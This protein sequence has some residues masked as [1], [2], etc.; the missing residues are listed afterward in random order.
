MGRNQK[1]AKR[2]ALITGVTGTLG[3]SFCQNHHKDYAIIGVARSGPKPAG[4]DII[5]HGDVARDYEDIIEEALDVHGKVDYLINNAATY[6]LKSIE[7]LTP[8]EML[9]VLNVNVVGPY[10]LTRELYLKFW[11]RRPE[12]NLIKHRQVLNVSSTSAFKQYDK[13]IAYGVSKCA[14]NNLSLHLKKELKG[15]NITSGTITPTSFPSIVTTEFVAG[16]IVDLD[17]EG[18][19]YEKTR[20]ARNF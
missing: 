13:Q 6:A 9:E 14:L 2:V 8:E 12:K 4:C 15:C 16:W 11:K 19:N 3:K 5:I 20:S 1:M 7:E 10:A 17:K 18:L